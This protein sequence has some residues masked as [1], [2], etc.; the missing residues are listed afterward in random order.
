MSILN[1]LEIKEEINFN[2]LI[3]EGDEKGSRFSTGIGSNDDADITDVKDNGSTETSCGKILKNHS[4]A[5]NKKRKSS[6]VVEVSSA[7]LP[8]HVALAKKKH[9][10]KS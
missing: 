7:L 10:Q 3:V 2:A 9:K 5:R 1:P 6:T 4:T 8:S